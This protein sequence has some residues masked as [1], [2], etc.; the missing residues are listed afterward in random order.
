LSA[1]SPTRA[2]AGNRINDHREDCG[3]DSMIRARTLPVLGYKIEPWPCLASW[4]RVGDCACGGH[5]I[6]E[7]RER[8]ERTLAATALDFPSPRA[9]GVWGRAVRTRHRARIG[10]ARFTGHRRRLVG[11]KSLAGL[12]LPRPSR[13][14][15]RTN[16]LGA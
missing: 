11:A 3:S 4:E 1:L 8:E 2:R 5:Q 10:Q 14:A 7:K 15:A 16:S 12:R 6:G 13:R 9:D